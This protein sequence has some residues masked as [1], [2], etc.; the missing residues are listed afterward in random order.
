MLTLTRSKQHLI[1]LS[2]L[3]VLYLESLRLNHD[4][5]EEERSAG[6]HDEGDGAGH[7]V[8]P[9]GQGPRVLGGRGL[10]RKCRGKISFSRNENFNE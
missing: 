7:G 3:L 10:I 9:F 4:G 1:L 2:L 8:A 6:E 5:H